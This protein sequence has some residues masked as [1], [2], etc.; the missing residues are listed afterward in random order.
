MILRMRDVAICL[1]FSNK[2]SIS[3]SKIQLQKIIYLLDSI[4]EMLY[5]LSIKNG[6]HTYFHGPYDKNIQNAADSL[7]ISGFVDVK[8]IK[9][10][11]NSTSCE[12][13]LTQT[14]EAWIK[15]LIDIE[16]NTKFRST[17]A[18]YLLESL[19][20][21]NLFTEIVPLVY[22]EPMFVK[23]RRNGYGIDLNFDDLEENDMFNFLLMVLDAFEITKN[24][25]LVPFVCDLIITYLNKRRC[26]LA[27][28]NE[29][30]YQC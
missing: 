10:S 2:K 21:R 7:V 26:A 11:N 12:Y 28:T 24:K 19:I 30:E 18:Y 29:E 9:F 3:L 20:S 1:H 8:N 13:F 27:A 5:I 16:P 14:G 6:H 25:D 23:N 4:T 17:I 15:Y 22:A